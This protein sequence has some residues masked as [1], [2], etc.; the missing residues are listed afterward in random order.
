MR[1]PGMAYSTPTHLVRKSRSS[2]SFRTW[3][4]RITDFRRILEKFCEFFETTGYPKSSPNFSGV[5]AETVL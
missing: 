2:E 3:P 4:G 1:H 5:G